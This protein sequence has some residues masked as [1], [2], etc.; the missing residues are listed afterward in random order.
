MRFWSMKS[1]WVFA[2]PVVHAE[3][4]WMWQPTT[5]LSKFVIC[6]VP[7]RSVQEVQLPLSETR[8]RVAR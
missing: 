4:L 5:W 8:V 6:A 3:P 2:A 7:E 1:A